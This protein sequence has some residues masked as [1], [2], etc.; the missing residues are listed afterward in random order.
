MLGRESYSLHFVFCLFLFFSFDFGSF[1]CNRHINPSY[2]YL[3][4]NLEVSQS[5]EKK[6]TQSKKDNLLPL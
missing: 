4:T 6:E 5:N 1:C 3:S 2:I